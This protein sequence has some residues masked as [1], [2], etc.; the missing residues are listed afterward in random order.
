MN[1]GHNHATPKASDWNQ[2]LDQHARGLFLY[3]RQQT[4]CEA[5]AQ[6][7]LQDA[8]VEAWER[9]GDGTPPN[10]ASVYA[11][12]RHRAIDRARSDHRRSHRE[13]A[14][15]ELQPP[16]WF[17]ASPE[18]REQHQLIESAMRRLPDIYREVITLKIWGDLSFAQIA[19]ALDIPANTAASRYRY[20]VE[21]LRRRMKGVLV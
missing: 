16:C 15:A 3:A 9:A 8:V 20:A 17:D 4:R 13:N 10:L 6:D 7:L 14:T 5:D 18:E 21:E 1:S 2:W 12:V 19:E 11:L